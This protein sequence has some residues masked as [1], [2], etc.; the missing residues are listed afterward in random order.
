MHNEG[1]QKLKNIEPPV[2]HIYFQGL[3]TN[4]KLK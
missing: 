2:R 3:I 1:K 4:T